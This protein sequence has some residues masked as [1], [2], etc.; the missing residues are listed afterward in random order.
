MPRAWRPRLRTAEER[1]VDEKRRAP[2]G[3]LAGDDPAAMLGDDPA[4]DG[5]SEA[6]VRTCT[7]GIGPVE[8][9]E[10]A[11]AMLGRNARS[12]VGDQQPRPPRIRLQADLDRR[13]PVA[14]RVVEEY[15][16]QLA[17]G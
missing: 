17:K 3:R 15:P 6:G 16:K 13:A 4:R 9:L 11:L 2:D 10:H 8:P 14:V 12:V 5:K 1:E 7:C